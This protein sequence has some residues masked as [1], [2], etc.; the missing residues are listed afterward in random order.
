MMPSCSYCCNYILLWTRSRR[1]REKKDNLDSV[2]HHHKTF[3]R[4]K[5]TW[6][7]KTMIGIF[8][9]HQRNMVAIMQSASNAGP[10]GGEGCQAADSSIAHS[11]AKCCQF[12][13]QNF[14]FIAISCGLQKQ[15]QV[16]PCSKA[17]RR[18]DR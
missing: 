1:K 18:L 13:L 11:T 3:I 2:D 7:G 12:N 17:N 9:G 4:W 8:E 14:R 6:M 10:Q 5:I 15:K 16:W